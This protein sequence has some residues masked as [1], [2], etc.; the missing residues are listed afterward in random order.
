MIVTPLTPAEEIM[1][2]ASEVEDSHAS[3]TLE[4]LVIE[5][6]LNNDKL[7]EAENVSYA[8]IYIKEIYGYLQLLDEALAKLEKHALSIVGKD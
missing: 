3:I 1:G 4:L 6:A 7:A 5:E 2:C 8:R